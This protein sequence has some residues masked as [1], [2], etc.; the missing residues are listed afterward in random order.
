MVEVDKPVTVVEQ[1]PVSPPGRAWPNALADLVTELDPGR[2]Y[3]HDLPGL[4]DALGL[5][6]KALDRR[7]GW[8]R[9]R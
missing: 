1:V 6:L 9:H 2:G 4:A 8:R 3:D 5:V 7:P